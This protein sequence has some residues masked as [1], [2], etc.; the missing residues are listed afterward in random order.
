MKITEKTLEVKPN[1]RHAQALARAVNEALLEGD[2]VQADVAF[3][4]IE[5]MTFDRDRTLA[6]VF[7]N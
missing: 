2:D 3:F 7:P 5:R 4:A 1:N 6:I